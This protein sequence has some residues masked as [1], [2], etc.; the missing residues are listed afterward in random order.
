MSWSKVNSLAILICQLVCNLDSVIIHP[1]STL[2]NPF[3][4]LSFFS[5]PEL[6]SLGNETRMKDLETFDF[7][8]GLFVKEAGSKLF[9]F[10]HWEVIHEY[11]LG[12]VH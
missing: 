4:L 7:F 11:H 8:D 10:T 12:Q 5:D 1:D 3:L 9:E 2:H 6:I